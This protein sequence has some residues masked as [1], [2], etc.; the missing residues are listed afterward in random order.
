[1]K[2]IV[3]CSDGT[4]NVPDQTADGERR[5]SNVVHMARAIAPNPLEQGMSHAKAD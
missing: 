3:V 2:R 5:P 4:W 1:M